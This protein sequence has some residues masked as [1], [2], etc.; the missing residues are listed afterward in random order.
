MKNVLKLLSFVG[1]ALTIIPPVLLF[2][3]NLEMDSMKWIMGIGMAFWMSTAPF[4][5]NKAEG[6]DQSQ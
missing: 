4:W 6:S 5:I 3:G 2:M 1:L